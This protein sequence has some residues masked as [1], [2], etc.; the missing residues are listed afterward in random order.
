MNAE[1]E[2]RKHIAVVKHFLFEIIRELEKRAETHD[3]SK[4]ESPEAETFEKFTSE[5]RG[6]TY[7][8][9]KYKKLLDQMK[10]ALE[11]HYANN[12]HHPEHW[13]KGVNDMTIVDIV[14][15]LCDWKSATLRHDDGDMLKSIAINEKRFGLSPQLVSIFRNTVRALGWDKHEYPVGD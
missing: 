2:T 6:T 1:E 14:E 4:L 5:L 7:G 8:T 15:L 3:Q 10:P 11:H 9:D 13:Q 12:P